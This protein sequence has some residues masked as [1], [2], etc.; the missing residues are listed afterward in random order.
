MPCHDGILGCFLSV[1]TGI[2]CA[3]CFSLAAWA[4]FCIIDSTNLTTNSGYGTI[5][6]KEFSPNHPTTTFI[7]SGKIMV[8]VINVHPDS[9]YV[10][11]ETTEGSDS[12][13]VSQ[14]YFNAVSPSKRVRIEYARSRLSNKIYIKRIYD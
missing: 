8:P 5:V 10:K 4:C 2:L 11:V 9:W 6:S 7:M 3:L 13:K 1:S 12:V 14:E